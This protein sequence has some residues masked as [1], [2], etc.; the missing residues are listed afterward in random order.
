MRVLAISDMRSALRENRP[1]CPRCVP[2]D[3]VEGRHERF[4]IVAA[5]CPQPDVD[6]KYG[7]YIASTSREAGG[8]VRG[9]GEGE[10]RLPKT[11]MAHL[12]HYPQA[13]LLGVTVAGPPGSSG[14]NVTRSVT[15]RCARTAS[16]REAAT[17]VSCPIVGNP[18]SRV[19]TN[20]HTGR[21]FTRNLQ[22][23]QRPAVIA[24]PIKSGLR[25]TKNQAIRNRPSIPWG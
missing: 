4:R 17:W 11:K 9:L 21:L 13:E 7:C 18:R 2:I 20:G 23:G 25:S 12:V 19:L 8:I 5:C 22:K 24:N 1:F 14:L 6:Y 15:R 10:D 3:K 16:H